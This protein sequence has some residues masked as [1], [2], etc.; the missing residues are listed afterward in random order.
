VPEDPDVPPP[1]EPPPPPPKHGWSDARKWWMDVLKSVLTAIVGFWIAYTLLDRLQE[2]R[3]EKRARCSAAIVEVQQIKNDVWRVTDAFLNA[4]YA[5][6]EE[7][8]RWRDEQPTQPLVAW[9]TAM[10]NLINTVTAVGLR[11]PYNKEEALDVHVQALV[12]NAGKIHHVIRN[13][14]INRKLNAIDAY[15]AKFTGTAEQRKVD[16]EYVRVLAPISNKEVST[17]VDKLGRTFDDL[18]EASYGLSTEIDKFLNLG[19]STVCERI[20]IT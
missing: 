11:L 6:I 4:T 5:V 20:G 17:A 1:P 7:L 19:S 8:P 16:P 13:D 15:Y 10:N 14:L 2:S 12:K 18:R 9:E 3:T